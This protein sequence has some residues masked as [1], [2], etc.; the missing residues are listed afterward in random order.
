MRKTNWCIFSTLII[1]LRINYY[2][3][4]VLVNK[5]QNV[6][7]ISLS[8]KEIS[9]QRG[10]GGGGGWN[11][12]IFWQ[13]SKFNILQNLISSS[14]ERI[15][16]IKKIRVGSL[17]Y[18]LITNNRAIRISSRLFR[19]SCFHEISPPPLRNFYLT[20]FYF[21]SDYLVRLRHHKD[22]ENKKKNCL[23]RLKNLTGKCYLMNEFFVTHYP[24]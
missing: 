14:K 24:T 19:F 16:F 21:I 9:T 15:C 18:F 20:T 3:E 17:I 4:D 11:E 1:L 2:H 6:K 7:K 22:A 8:Y 12:K 5:I 13:R 23:H 10:S